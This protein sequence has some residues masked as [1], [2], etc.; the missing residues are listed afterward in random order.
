MFSKQI[1]FFL[2][3]SHLSEK[4]KILICRSSLPEVFLRKG[5]MKI[6]RK[7][8]GEHSCRSVI[9]IKLLATLL[10]SHF[11]MGVLL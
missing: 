7:F 2:V 3:I 1:V 11:G 4:P 9:S 8:T 5:V 6:C 10:K